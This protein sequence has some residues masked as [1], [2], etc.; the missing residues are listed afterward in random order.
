LSIQAFFG[1]LTGM[2]NFTN[3]VKSK[4]FLSVVLS[5]LLII[6][7]NSS[8]TDIPDVISIYSTDQQPPVANAK[9]TSSKSTDTVWDN[10]SH[11]F[12]LDHRINSARVQKEIHRILAD[13]ARLYKILNSAVPY[14]HYIYKKTQMSGLP[15]EI[16]LIPFIESEFN[17]NDRSNKGALGLWQLMPGTA[18]DLGVKVKSGYDGRRNVVASTNAAIAYFKDLAK[19]F[20]GNWYLAIAAYNCGDG[21]VRSSMRRTGRDSFWNLPLPRDTK[22]YVPRLLAIAAIIQNPEHYGVL[23]PPVKDQK[24][25]TQVKVRKPITLTHLA[26]HISKSGVNIDTLRVLN[27][28]YSQKKP[29]PSKKTTNTFLIPAERELSIKLELENYK[30]S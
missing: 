12:K 4:S 5:C 11:E 3:I 20:N 27:P 26:N 6:T 2:Q 10:M 18:R 8:T 16:A 28:D 17:P 24:Y 25:F 30:L 29:K 15:A 19:E 9:P 22:Y 14:I 7:W 1:K 21:R 23:L 13:Q